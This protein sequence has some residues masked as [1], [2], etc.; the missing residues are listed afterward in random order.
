MAIYDMALVE[1]LFQAFVE[2]G[3]PSR[4][5]TS[6]RVQSLKKEIRLEKSRR[7]RNL[8]M[9]YDDLVLL[10]PDSVIEHWSRG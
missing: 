6:E 2:K 7:W 9:W 3:A 5:E 1:A 8:V 10:K 4:E